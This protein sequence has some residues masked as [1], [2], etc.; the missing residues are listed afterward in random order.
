MYSR[1]RAGAAAPRAHAARLRS[2]WRSVSHDWQCRPRGPFLPCELTIPARCSQSRGPFL[3]YELTIPARCSQGR[4]PFLPSGPRERCCHGRPSTRP[5]NE[6]VATSRELARRHVPSERPEPSPHP[7][8]MA[9]VGGARE[10]AREIAPASVRESASLSRPS[11][12]P[13]PRWPS[14]SAPLPS[15]P[16]QLPLLPSLQPA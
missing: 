6:R 8:R 16:L 2:G 7:W 14:W 5:L 12:S 11:P 3:P 4:G 15:L 10:I 1:A 13:S 9:S